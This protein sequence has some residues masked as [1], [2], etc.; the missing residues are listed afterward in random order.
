[1]VDSQL[2]WS[3][4][5]KLVRRGNAFVGSEWYSIYAVGV[6]GLCRD[7]HMYKYITHQVNERRSYAVRS[8]AATNRHATRG[9]VLCQDRL[10]TLHE[11][12]QQLG[13][14]NSSQ[15]T[16]IFARLTLRNGYDIGPV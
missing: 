6:D 7:A 2:T 5:I 13:S 1:M 9:E 4:H 15:I 10:H 16:M 8:I 3:Q 12:K 11:Q 14:K